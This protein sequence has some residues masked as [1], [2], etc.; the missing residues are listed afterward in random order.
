MR[1]VSASCN[2]YGCTPTYYGLFSDL[3]EYQHPIVID[4]FSPSI[5]LSDLYVKN[6]YCTLVATKLYGG[7]CYLQ[8]C[9]RLAIA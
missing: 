4:F 3:F 8:P 2:Y 6:L 7:T 1:P 9:A 5:P